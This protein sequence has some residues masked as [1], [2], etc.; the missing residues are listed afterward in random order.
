MK[1]HQNL[2]RPSS[3]SSSEDIKRTI[4]EDFEISRVFIFQLKPYFWRSKR[5][6]K[7]RF[8]K[9][10]FF[11]FQHEKVDFPQM[12]EHQNLAR[13]PSKSA[14]ADFK[15]TISEDFQ[16]SRFFISQLKTLALVI[17]NTSKIKVFEDFIFS[18]ST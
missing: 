11:R 4:S 12:K 3:K 1:E 14:S 16:I 2:V 15:R 5:A 18:I 9:T 10:S 8:L 6:R 13:P 7:P 17:E